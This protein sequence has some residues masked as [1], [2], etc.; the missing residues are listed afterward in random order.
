MLQIRACLFIEKVERLSCIFINLKML[1]VTGKRTFFPFLFISK[2][3]FCWPLRI[4]LTISGLRAGSAIPV[5][6]GITPKVVFKYL[7]IELLVQLFW[8]IMYPRLYFL[9]LW[10]LNIYKYV[11]SKTFYFYLSTQ[12]KIKVFTRNNVLTYFF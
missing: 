1:S 3:Q 8:T 7:V 10:E 6:W 11:H 9:R 2:S 5:I 4:D 12:L